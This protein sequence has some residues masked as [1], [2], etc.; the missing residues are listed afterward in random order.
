[1]RN[2]F[3][4]TENFKKLQAAM[5]AL[6]A[7]GS[8]EACL[9]VVDGIPGLG[10]TASTARV[11]ALGDCVFIRARRVWSPNDMMEA[12]LLALQVQPAH[13]FSKRFAQALEALSKR[14]EQAQQRDESFAVIVDEVDYI[15]KSDLM[16]STLRDL[17][18][19]LEIPFILVGMGKVRG[20]LKRFPQVTSRVGQYVEF[21]PF[22]PEDTRRFM[23]GL[24]EYPLADDLIAEVHRLSGGLS[25]E[26]KEAVAHIERFAA[27]QGDG[28]PIQLSDMRGQV[29]MN[30]RATSQPIYV[31]S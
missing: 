9:M 19:M 2:D 20:S 8:R 25:R 4:T 10:K 24:C 18:D 16:L 7:R 23:A 1:M 12:L 29:I 15:C 6:E 21:S 11:A 3:I 27:R 22:D 26:I 17:S 30:N 31:G 5:V 13:S 14:E 28:T